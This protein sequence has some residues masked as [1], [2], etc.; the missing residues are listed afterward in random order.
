MQQCKI[1]WFLR[2]LARFCCVAVISF[3]ITAVV[4]SRLPETQSKVMYLIPAYSNC[5][6]RKFFLRTLW[7]TDNSAADMRFAEMEQ[8]QGCD[9]LFLGS[10]HVMMG[11]DTKSASDI[12]VTV[13]NIGTRRQTPLHSYSILS[14]LGDKVQPRAVAIDLYWAMFDNQT[15]EATFDLIRYTPYSQSLSAMVLRSINGDTIRAWW[16]WAY[17]SEVLRKPVSYCVTRP[18]LVGGG[19]DTQIIYHSGG[20]EASYG[21]WTSPLFLPVMSFDIEE[22]QVRYVEKM[23]EWCEKRDIPVYLVTLP[24]TRE[25][26]SS[27]ANYID[28]TGKMRSIAERKKT[29]KYLDMNSD[30]MLYYLL[31]S[32]EHFSDADHLNG[33]GA[34]IVTRR[35]LRIIG[36]EE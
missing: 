10:S 7:N 24:V 23:I 20:Y 5:F 30:V 36:A 12:G 31:K 16:C 2:R 27:V 13:L 11:I 17:S 15:T 28:F 34:S 25:Y 19:P 29:K 21:N 1:G 35:F 18:L 22:R 3:T 4:V 8:Y 6:L 26:A 9:I 33:A 14:S 32:E